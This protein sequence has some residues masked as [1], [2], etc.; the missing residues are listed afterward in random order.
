M[1]RYRLPC[2]LLV[3]ILLFCFSSPLLAEQFGQHK[4]ILLLN[5]Y[6]QGYKWTDDQTQGALEGLGVVKNGFKVFTENMSTKLISSEPYFAV[7]ANTFE[8]KFKHIRFDL[9]IATDDD[10]FAFLERYRDKLF[11][12]TPVVFCGVNWF[13]PESVPAGFK[14]YTGINEDADIPATLDLMLKLHPG[15]RKIYIIADATTTGRKIHAQ[16]DKVA[17]QYK[18]N[19]SFVFLDDMEI[20]E[21]INIVGNLGKDSLVLLTSFQQDKSGQF[22]EFSESAGLISKSSKVPCYGLWDFNL[23]FGI[24]GGMLT[25]GHAQG[26]AAGEA[27]LRILNGEK[28]DSIAVQMKSPNRFMFDYTQLRRWNI[29]SSVLPTDC[30][31]INKP[32]SFYALHKSLVWETSFGFVGLSIIII[33][34]IINIRGRKQSG[35]ELRASEEKY[36]LI[37]DT[38]DEGVWMLDYQGR[39]TFINDRMAD[40]IGYSKEEILGHEFTSFMF[41]ED[42][43]DHEARMKTRRQGLKEQYQRRVR[44]KNGQ[45]VLVHVSAVPI[46]ADDNRVAGSFAMFTDITEMKRVEDELIQYHNN[47]EVIVKQRTAELAVAKE[48]AETANN[49][50]SEFLTTMS[51]EIRTPMNA[52]IGMTGLLRD[53]MLTVDQH[54]YLGV[55]RAAS[56]HLLT[57][58]DDI[59]DFSKIE[60]KKLALVDMPFNLHE[61]LVDTVAMFAYQAEEKGLAISFMIKKDVP[62]SLVG[63]SQRLRQILVNLIGNALKFTEKGGVEVNVD[64]APE[65]AV[66]PH[67]DSM[68]QSTQSTVSLLFSVQD[69]GIGIPVSEQKRI[70]DSFTQLDG[71][72]RRKCGGVGLGL[73]ITKQLITLMG[74]GIGLESRLGW[75]SRFFF[76]IRL[77]LAPPHERKAMMPEGIV[78]SEEVAPPL[79]ILIADDLVVNQEIITATLERRGH[80]VRQVFNGLEALETLQQERFDLV[81]MDVQM[82]VMDG[83]E[84]VQQIRALDDRQIATVPVI[85]LTAH[86]VKGDRERFLKA[87]MDAYVSKPVRS[88][89]LLRVINEVVQK[90]NQ[91]SW[92]AAAL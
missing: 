91:Q 72:Y 61:I 4:N 31:V 2:L 36:R 84:A 88:S 67:D 59:L 18:D 57:L 47:L 14:E 62:V 9:I 15:T 65:E 19:V 78:E 64:L 5:S 70:Y 3:L 75:G 55:V 13:N 10:A 8:F 37:V 23:G 6:H 92:A 53:T 30:V 20:S 28:A 86:A 58:I 29:N 11:P 33:M 32:V 7:L 71:S 44:H 63:D 34:L 43:P 17:S 46:I 90:K 69:T 39:T 52:I 16:F 76:T 81:L 82:P 83:L 51:H 80:T 87:G 73:A 89:E 40:M 54:H 50:K 49:A 38:A 48:A 66:L 77:H 24:I 12:N 45:V 27:G 68:R 35:E 26:K 42:L 21:I 85:A 41:K 74:G 25:S 56:E 1:Y 22:F 60:A 79:R